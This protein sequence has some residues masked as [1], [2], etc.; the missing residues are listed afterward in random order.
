MGVEGEKRPYISL[1][2]G[3]VISTLWYVEN[4]SLN[5]NLNKNDELDNQKGQLWSIS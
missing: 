5:L 4:I 1:Y 2:D 3:H